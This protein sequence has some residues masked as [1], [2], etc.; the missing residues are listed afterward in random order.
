VLALD[1]SANVH[2]VLG[3]HREQDYLL[4][5]KRSMRTKVQEFLQ[6]YG[7]SGRASSM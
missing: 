3:S 6:L 4:A 7:S 1:D 5:G 2:D